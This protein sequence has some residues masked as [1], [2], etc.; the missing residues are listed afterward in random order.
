[1]VVIPIVIVVHFVSPFSPHYHDPISIALPFSLIS[2]CL[3]IFSADTIQD[4]IKIIVFVVD[5]RYSYLYQPLSLFV[6]CIHS[7]KIRAI[8]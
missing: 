4:S 7:L 8:G 2:P 1:M 6:V 5:H 3:L